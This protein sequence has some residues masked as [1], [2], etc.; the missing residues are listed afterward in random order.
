MAV[1]YSYLY[2][3]SMDKGPINNSPVDDS[4]VGMGLRLYEQVP[5]FDV[6]TRRYFTTSPM[7]VIRAWKL[8]VTAIKNGY[9]PTLNYF[10]D[11]LDLKTTDPRGRFIAN[12]EPWLCLC[13]CENEF[14]EPVIA[15]GFDLF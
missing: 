2:H 6:T 8:F 10:Y 12:N 11:E 13:V 15:I 3:S 9:E 7:R 1:H 14:L 5:F 4:L